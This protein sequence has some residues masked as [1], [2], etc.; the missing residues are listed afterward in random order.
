ML[1]QQQ[2]K[3]KNISL[4]FENPN[5]HTETPDTRKKSHLRSSES[6]DDESESEETIVTQQENHYDNE[7]FY[8]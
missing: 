6:K 8:D 1:T 2:Q 7:S 3:H 5:V 4:Y